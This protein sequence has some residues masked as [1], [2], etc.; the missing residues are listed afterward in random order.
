MAFK[1]PKDWEKDSDDLFIHKTGVRI[2]KTTYKDKDGWFLIPVDMKEPVVEFEENPEGRD[3]A[4]ETFTELKK[5]AK[6]RKPGRKPAKKK[7]KPKAKK[8][9]KQGEDGADT[10]ADADE[11]E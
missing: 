1:T 4:F 6:K 5:A 8:P 11:E 9:K 2:H 7:A 10:D 3:K